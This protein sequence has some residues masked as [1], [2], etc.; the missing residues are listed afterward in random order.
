MGLLKNRLNLVGREEAEERQG[1]R[2]EKINVCLEM[3]MQSQKADG[4]GDL[5]TQK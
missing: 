5:I 1:G 4:K 2:R 3:L